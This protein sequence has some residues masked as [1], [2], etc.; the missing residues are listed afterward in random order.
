M[1]KFRAKSSKEKLKKVKKQ[2]R[3]AHAIHRK[4]KE[5]IQKL[6]EVKKKNRDTHVIHQK[7]KAYK[8]WKK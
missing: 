2:D 6:E 5:S 3:D 7:K 1:H 4:K 8:S